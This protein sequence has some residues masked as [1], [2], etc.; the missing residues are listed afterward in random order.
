MPYKN[1]II[2]IYQIS[3]ETEKQ[4]YYYIGSS[5]NCKQRLNQH[6]NNLRRLKHDNPIMQ[7]LFNKCGEIRFNSKI[8]ESFEEASLLIAKEQY[9]IDLI[10]KDIRI[11]IAKADRKNQTEEVK[12]KISKTR[13]ERIKQGLINLKPAENAR[14]RK[15]EL[16]EINTLYFLKHKETQKEITANVIDL[17]L[18]FDVPTK[19][20]K[21]YIREVLR[22]KSRNKTLYGYYIE[23]IS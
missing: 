4:T 6:L 22:P 7:N 20:I 15:K 14:I 19:V 9:Y 5:V 11:N 17:G 18:F 16:I 23:R 10:P 2:G 1:K 13:S 21:K 3:F 12:S 8:I